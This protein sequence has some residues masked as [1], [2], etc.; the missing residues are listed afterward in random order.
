MDIGAF[1]GCCA[2]RII[3]NLDGEYA[4]QHNQ[5]I[6]ALDETEIEK[7]LVAS[8][9][10]YGN[11]AS[12]LVA[13]TNSNQPLVA[14]VLERNGFKALTKVPSAIHPNLEITMWVR[15]NREPRE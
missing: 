9:S 15:N 14:T 5:I 2:G 1:P 3:Y 6:P 4:R 11:V 7:T 8:I 13:T 12:F 10:L